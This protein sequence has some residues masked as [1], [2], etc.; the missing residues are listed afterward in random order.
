MLVAPA[1]LALSSCGIPA[2]GV[3]EAGGPASGITPVTSVYFVQNGTL[4]AVPRTTAFPGDAAAALE[5]LIGGPTFDEA[6][7]RLGTA[8]PRPRAPAAP[9]TV[10]GR[11]DALLVKLP[12]GMGP[13]ADLA[14]RQVICTAAAARHLTDESAATVTIEVTDSRGRRVRGTDEGCPGR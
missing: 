12:P 11:G 1:L 14:T 6:R 4:V 7:K 9:P 5:L 10:T 8:M 13:L 3:V 2:T